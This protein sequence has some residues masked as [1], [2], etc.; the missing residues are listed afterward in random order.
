MTV[1]HSLFAEDFLIYSFSP[2]PTVG[3][4]KRSQQGVTPGHRGRC[5]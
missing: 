3:S 4:V 1:T 2:A 5:A